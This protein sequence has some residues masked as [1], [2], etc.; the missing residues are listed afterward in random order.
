MQAMWMASK[1]QQAKGVSL[2]SMNLK[3]SFDSHRAHL[4]LNCEPY[5][6]QTED[7]VTQSLEIVQCVTMPV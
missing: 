3:A 6:L 2:G 1:T 4:A 5:D 7:V